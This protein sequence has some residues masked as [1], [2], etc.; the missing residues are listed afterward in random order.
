MAHSNRIRLDRE[1]RFPQ[2]VHGEAK[3]LVGVPRHLGKEGRRGAYISYLPSRDVIYCKK[4]CVLPDPSSSAGNERK[5][6][7]DGPFSA[8]EDDFAS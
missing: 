2:K 6:W 5:M 1:R 4:H 3:E 8:R 7:E